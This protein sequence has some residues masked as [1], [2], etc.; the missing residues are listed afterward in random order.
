MTGPMWIE[1]DGGAPPTELKDRVPMKDLLADHRK[2]WVLKTHLGNIVLRRLTRVSMEQVAIRLS[3][4]Q[5]EYFRLA[6]AKVPL[7]EKMQQ[8][9]E[10]SPEEFKSA[11]DIAAHMAPFL[12]EYFLPCFVEPALAN[13][14][15]YDALVSHL[16]QD[17][18]EQL[19]ELL[20]QLITTRP[21]GDSG[22]A[23]LQIAKEYGVPLSNDLT[24]ENMTARQ[25]TVMQEA[26]E[27]ERK[28]TA[29]AVK[30]IVRNQ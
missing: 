25:F 5:E 6:E 19:Q 10:L 13:V 23:E 21:I 18:Q 24:M 26:M 3:Q 29:K 28:E 4:S 9:V 20:A 8:G 12:V 11:A 14:E 22:K 16:R 30:D 15:E 1:Y 27:D 7:W 17:E 2:Q